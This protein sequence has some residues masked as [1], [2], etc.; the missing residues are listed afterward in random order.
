ML[1]LQILAVLGFVVSLYAYGVERKAKQNAAYKAICDIKESMSCTKAF[2]SPYGKILGVSNAVGGLFFYALLFVL[3]LFGFRQY[4]FY[5][6]LA[7]FFGT[8][9]LAYVSYVKMRNFCV[10]CHI[11]Y[12]I[13]LLLLFFATRVFL[14][15]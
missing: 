14:A 10:I 15:V 6:T 4:L 1:T 5:L 3:T 12:L 8:M 9:Y 2:T 11:I 7:S 13:N